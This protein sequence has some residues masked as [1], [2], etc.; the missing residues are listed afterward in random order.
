MLTTDQ[1]FQAINA[2]SPASLKMR[3]P[4]DWY[5]EQSV[6]IRDGGILIGEYGNGATPQDAIEEHFE[7]LT[8]VKYPRYIVASTGSPQRKAVRWNGFMWDHISEEKPA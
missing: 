8:S 7:K 4:C 6:E 3:Q 1:K 2:L 5:V